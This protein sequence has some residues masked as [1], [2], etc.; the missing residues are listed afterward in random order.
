MKKEITVKQFKEQVNKLDESKTLDEL[1]TS[2][3]LSSICE[4]TQY[5]L[6]ALWDYDD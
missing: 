5:Y 6:K 2:G 4:N 1:Y 3:K